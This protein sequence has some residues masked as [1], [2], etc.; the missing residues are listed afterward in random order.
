MIVLAMP[1]LA[2]LRMLLMAAR[3]WSCD[4]CGTVNSDS[5]TSCYRCGS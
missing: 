1:F 3:N 2:Q 5:V 4:Q